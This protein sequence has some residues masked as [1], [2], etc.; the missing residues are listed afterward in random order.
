M[1][2]FGDCGDL[3]IRH[4]LQFQKEMFEDLAHARHYVVVHFERLELGNM[5]GGLIVTFI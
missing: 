2:R 3:S 1:G 4:W 5:T